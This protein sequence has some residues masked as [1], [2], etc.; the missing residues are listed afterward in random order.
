MDSMTDSMDMS[1]SQLQG[2]VK[3]RG[4]W[5]AAVRGVTKSWTW[6]SKWITT[7][8]PD[9]IHPSFLPSFQLLPLLSLISHYWFCISYFICPARE[10]IKPASPLRVALSPTDI[11]HLC[12][13][14]FCFQQFADGKHSEAGKG[15]SQ[16]SQWYCHQIN[17]EEFATSR[18]W[19][20]CLGDACHS[21]IRK[22]GQGF[23]H[24]HFTPGLK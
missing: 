24:A 1:L 8:Y 19:A 15:G 17:T 18:T 16:T 13:R 21:E 23:E 14:T 9:H 4:A 5:H 3:H 10:A 20:D 22:R 12:A 2:T 6:P 7:L 11:T